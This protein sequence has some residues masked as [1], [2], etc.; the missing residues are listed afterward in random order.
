VIDAANAWRARLEAARR[1]LPI[2]A[3]R[4]RELWGD[5]Q[6]DL[7][8]IASAEL[9]VGQD[10]DAARAEDPKVYGIELDLQRTAGF[11]RVAFR[12]AFWHLGH[13]ASWRDAV[14]DASSRGG[15]AD[16]N[17]AIVGALLG[18]RDGL[19]A[20]PAAWIDRVLAVAQPGPMDWANAHHPRHLLGIATHLRAATAAGRG[21]R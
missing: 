7:A 4:L 13:T 19:H 11:V 5:D 8:A 10:L 14:V 20:I 2:A 1:A 6:D 3:A 16:T 18:A 21:A 17:A 12:M 9:A 15:D